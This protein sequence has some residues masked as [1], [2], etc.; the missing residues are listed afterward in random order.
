MAASS[1]PKEASYDWCSDEDQPLPNPAEMGLT[2]SLEARFSALTGH[3]LHK[4]SRIEGKVVRSDYLGYDTTKYET[5]EME[6]AGVTV[7]ANGP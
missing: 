5:V 1:D 4:C 6:E 7:D 2:K 3:Y